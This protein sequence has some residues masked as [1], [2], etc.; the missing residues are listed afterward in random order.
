MF[1]SWLF[2]PW[3][4]K[5]TPWSSLNLFLVVPP[6]TPM[7]QAPSPGYEWR[8]VWLT[9]C[10]SNH[11]HSSPY[12]PC[13][14]LATLALPFN[15]LFKNVLPHP[16]LLHKSI[17]CKIFW[18]FQVLLISPFTEFLKHILFVGLWEPLSCSVL[19]C[20]VNFHIHIFCLCNLTLSFSR[21]GISY[22][23]LSHPSLLLFARAS[24]S[25]EF[26]IFQIMI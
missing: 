23:F 12:T 6:K 5:T 4:F 14:Q 3:L 21:A 2:R 16:L 13:L 22:T 8:V 1:G 26:H 11:T 19:D 25:L 9:G 20:Y 24:S 10:L 17:Y 18:F 15:F 7:T